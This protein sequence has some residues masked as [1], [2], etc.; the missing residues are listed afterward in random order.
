ML[1]I[2]PA[3]WDQVVN[4]KGLVPPYIFYSRVITSKPITNINPTDSNLLL[5]GSE[6]LF[7]SLLMIDRTIGINEI[8]PYNVYWC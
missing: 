6:I 5:P 4:G 3:V 7:T 1:F 8:I 2:S